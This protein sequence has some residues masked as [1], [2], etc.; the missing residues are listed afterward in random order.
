MFKL[1]QKVQHQG[2]GGGVLNAI[3]ETI[4]EIAETTKVIVAGEGEKEMIRK[5]HEYDY[6]DLKLD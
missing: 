3:G 5:T 6:G 2:E 4:A 1:A